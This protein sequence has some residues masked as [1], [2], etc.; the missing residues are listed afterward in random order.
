VPVYVYKPINPEIAITTN[1]CNNLKAV[2]KGVNTDIAVKCSWTLHE[3]SPGSPAIFSSTEDSF[4]YT[5][6]LP[7]KYFVKCY[8]IPQSASCKCSGKTVMDSLDMKSLWPGLDFQLNRNSVCLADSTKVY[9]PKSIQQ[10]KSNLKYAWELN[11]KP[12]NPTKP[13]TL[14]VRLS[15]GST[16]KLT[17]SDDSGCILSKSFILPVDTIYFLQQET[18]L[19]RCNPDTLSLAAFSPYSNSF[20]QGGYTVINDANEVEFLAEESIFKYYYHRPKY[21]VL[22]TFTSKDGCV[23]NFTTDIFIDTT[24]IRFKSLPSLVCKGMKTLSL[25]SIGATPKG[26][27]WS[28]SQ[29]KDSTISLTNLGKYP[30]DIV[31]QYQIES[32][33]CVKSLSDTL[34]VIDTLK[35]TLA[36]AGPVCKESKIWDAA[37]E[38]KFGTGGDTTSGTWYS[39]LMGLNINSNGIVNPRK[40]AAGIYPVYRYSLSKEGCSVQHEGKVEI[41]PAVLNLSANISALMGKPPLVV[42]FEG[43]NSIAG[44]TSYH[45][46]FGDTK[47]SPKD[48]A[49]GASVSYTYNDTGRYTPRLIGTV[50]SCKDT[51]VLAT[52]NVGLM[53]VESHTQSLRVQLFPNPSDLGSGCTL[54]VN[55]PSQQRFIHIYNTVG[56]RIS[57]HQ[58]SANQDR[59]ELMAPA[60]GLYFVEVEGTAK[61]IQWLVE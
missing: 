37:K 54:W 39:P 16:I 34:R 27:S 20:V 36:T 43:Q 14:A 52:I 1:G 23:S 44:A 35:N 7:E 46:I 53:S 11:G 49:W 19:E 21:Q 51:V 47:Q 8:V 24:R 4:T 3:K 31:I 18:F 25:S 57:V 29:G 58:L 2:L 38:L 56:T 33:G 42:N 6:L 48:T 12:V 60:P 15:A 30:N 32:S 59:L 9:F 13:D 41:L 55:G 40:S 22:S 61:S 26:G 17:L 10:F 50:G 45:W 5:G 28:N